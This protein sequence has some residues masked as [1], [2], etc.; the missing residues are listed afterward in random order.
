[1][2][3]TDAEPTHRLILAEMTGNNSENVRF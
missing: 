3:F 1:M 2:I